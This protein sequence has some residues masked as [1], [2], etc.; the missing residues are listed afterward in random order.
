MYKLT[1]CILILSF[2][3]YS[4][5]SN[6]TLARVQYES[7]SPR[8]KMGKEVWDQKVFNE[9]KIG[10]AGSVSRRTSSCR[11]SC[12]P[13]QSWRIERRLRHITVKRF[14]LLDY[15]PIT[16]DVLYY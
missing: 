3:L 7:P 6:P 5:L 1:V 15:L 16:C 13:S 10:A 4:R 14:K 2:L 12:K 9:I 11:T 8:K